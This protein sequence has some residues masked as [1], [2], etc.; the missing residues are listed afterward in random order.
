MNIG[1]LRGNRDIIKF[2]KTKVRR[3]KAKIRIKLGITCQK[4][5]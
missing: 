5:N 4:I 3:Y 2:Q 1:T